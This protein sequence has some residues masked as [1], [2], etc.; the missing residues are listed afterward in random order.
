MLALGTWI[1]DKGRQYFDGIFDLSWETNKKNAEIKNKLL[2][3][4][5]QTL[6]QNIYL[7]DHCNRQLYNKSFFTIAFE[8]TSLEIL[9]LLSILSETYSFIRIR[10]L[11]NINAVNDLEFS[12]QLQTVTDPTQ[13]C[14]ST[15]GIIV[16]TDTRHEGS[17][18]NLTL[19]QRYLKGNFK[20]IIIGSNLDLTFPTL[21]FGSNLKKLTGLL[22]GNHLICQDLKFSQKPF[23][24]FNK[25]INKRHDSSNVVNMLEALKDTGIVTKTWNG[26]NIL[27]PSLSE[28]GIQNTALFLPINIKNLMSFSSLYF[29]NI[30]ERNLMAVEKIIKLRLLQIDLK[31]PQQQAYKK[32]F[33]DQNAIINNNKKFYTY[34]S[35]S[36]EYYYIPTTVFY[37]NKE[38]FINT[39]GHF[40]RTTKLVTRDGIKNS[41]QMLRK[42]S[43][44]FKITLSFLDQKD[45]HMIIFNLKKLK[46]F[47]NFINFQF[48]ATRTLNNISFYLSNKTQ[49]F[50]LYKKTN[51]FKFKIKKISCSK[52]KYWLDDFFTGGKDEFSHKSLV[53]TDC[54]RNVRKETTNFF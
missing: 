16:A 35:Q 5:L 38:T 1:T 41:W 11:E 34:F 14:L 21:F 28:V 22:E 49:P 27:N 3:K 52:L 30:S 20:C 9:S 29:L 18:L 19:R 15:L 10:R 25:E 24:L 31:M 46:D 12:N 47:K 50:I 4:L 42:L 23:L 43:K 26:V 7:Y 36:T 45:N 32:I 33:I 37:E 6:S 39:E 8:N 44:H 13:L 51:Y 40:K 2:L 48:Y 17:S 54:S 53:L